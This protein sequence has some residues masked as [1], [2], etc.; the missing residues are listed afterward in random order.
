MFVRNNELFNELHAVPLKH[1]A[2]GWAS[3][4]K[5]QV[6]GRRAPYW[7]RVFEFGAETGNSQTGKSA[8]LYVVR[9]ALAT[10]QW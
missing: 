5:E 9:I 7:A 8:S 3:S 1:C 4:W 10:Y 2:L 6:K